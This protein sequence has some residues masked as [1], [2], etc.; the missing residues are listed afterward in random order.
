MRINFN[1]KEG[2]AEYGDIR[3]KATRRV[4]DAGLPMCRALLAAGIED[5]RADFYDEA[6]IHCF[7]IKS[8]LWGSSR[9]LSET[10]AGLRIVPW[11][12]FEMRDA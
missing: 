7:T 4:G 5:G 11:K 6:G 8:I 3:I 12:P 10:D 9:A 2:W 1:R